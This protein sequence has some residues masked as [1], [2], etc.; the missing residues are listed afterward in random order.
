[1]QI[2]QYRQGSVKMSQAKSSN[3]LFDEWCKAEINSHAVLNQ[4][5]DDMQ[6]PC[7]IE[8]VKQSDK[9]LWNFICNPTSSLQAILLKLKIACHF[10][11][12][13]KEALDPAN[14]MVAPRAIISALHD[15]ENIV[16]AS[17]C[18]DSIKKHDDALNSLAGK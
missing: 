5:A 2:Y 9:A 1:M 13:S 7:Y 6:H 10:D 11:D 18:A 3:L 14:T 17:L 15:L 4:V 8:A 16:I 12:F